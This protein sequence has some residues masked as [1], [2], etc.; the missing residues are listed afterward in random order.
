MALQICCGVTKLTCLCDKFVS[1]K[2]TVRDMDSYE[3]G[4]NLNLAKCPTT[5]R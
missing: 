5:A 1:S 2:S 3:N 4:H